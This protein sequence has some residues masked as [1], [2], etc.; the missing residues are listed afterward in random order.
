MFVFENKY[1]AMISNKIA[2]TKFNYFKAKKISH[3][4]LVLDSEMALDFT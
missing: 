2:L 1:D 3:C 4:S